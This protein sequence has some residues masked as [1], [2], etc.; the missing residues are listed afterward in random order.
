[1]QRQNVILR[2]AAVIGLGLALTGLGCGGPID[3]P[4][5]TIETQLQQSETGLQAVHGTSDQGR[6]QQ[7]LQ[8]AP[9]LLDQCEVREQKNARRRRPEQRMALRRAENA[10]EPAGLVERE[11]EELRTHDRRGNQGTNALVRAM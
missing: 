7:Q 3:A 4:Q 9:G 5:G 6:R 10:T 2:N 1:M 11:V 8:L